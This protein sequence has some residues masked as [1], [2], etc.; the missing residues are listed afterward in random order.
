MVTEKNLD[1]HELMHIVSTPE[2]N[3]QELS[4]ELAHATDY[5]KEVQAALLLV[6][7]IELGKGIK[8]SLLRRLQGRPF[9]MQLHQ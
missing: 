2:Q 9:P 6:K 7:R 3:D 5:I 4:E 8:T 1:K